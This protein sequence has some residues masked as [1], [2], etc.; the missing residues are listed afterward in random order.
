MNKATVFSIAACAGIACTLACDN[1]DGHYSTRS[2]A[3]ES[4]PDAG[5][6]GAANDDGG[7]AALAPSAA[8]A[9]DAAVDPSSP[10]AAVKSNAPCTISADCQSGQHCDLGECYQECNVSSPCDGGK[11]C[12][13]RGRCLAKGQPDTDPPPLVTKLGTVRAE[14]SVVQLTDRDDELRVHLITDSKNEVR[15]RVEISAPYLTISDLRGA[16]H[17]DLTLNLAVHPSEAGGKQVSGSVRVITNL[18]SV[19]ISTPMRGS[20]TGVYQGTMTYGG[21]MGGPQIGSTHV[22][23][24]LSETQGDILARFAPE[25]S[26]LFP[27]F[28]GQSAATGSGSFTYSD[29]VDIVMRQRIPK[30]FAGDDDPYQR[31]I[32]REVRFHLS[33]GDRGSLDGTFQESIY[34][35]FASPLSLSGRAHFERSPCDASGC[36]PDVETGGTSPAMPAGDGE[37]EPDF[38]S[39]FSGWA[40]TGCTLKMDAPDPA[41]MIQGSA[42]VDVAYHGPFLQLLSGNW[43]L[44]TD[45]PLGDIADTCEADLKKTALDA[46]PKCAQIAPVA[47]RLSMISASNLGTSAYDAFGTL[48]A[49]TV[50]VPLFIA[51][52]D[53]VRAVKDS[54]VQGYRAEIDR[55]KHARDLLRAPT[56]WVLHP[57]LL[58]YLRRADPGAQQR[59]DEAPTS[60]AARTLSRLLFVRST[61]DAEEARIAASSIIGT[62][63]SRRSAA[64]KDGLLAL[65]DAATLY[66]IASSWT[67]VPPELGAAFVDVLTPMDAGFTAF[68]EKAHVLGVADDA[69]PNVYD[70]SRPGTN[71]EQLLDMANSRIGSA[72]RDET[73]FTT[74]GR[75]F[76]DDED[77]LAQELGQLVNGYEAQIR[78]DCGDGFDLV[79]ADWSTCGGDDKGIVGTK[80]IAIDEALARMQSAEARVE[81]KMKAIDIEQDRISQVTGV[82]RGTIAFTDSTGQ[83]LDAIDRATAV[84]NGM[85]KALEIASHA[86]CWNGGAPLAEA[87][88]AFAIE[89]ARGE[90]DVQRQD[91]Q[92]Y[93]DMRVQEDNLK[94]EQIQSA[95]TV[96]G[97]LVDMAQARIETQEDAIGV[98]AA[99]VDAENAL[100][101]AK[102]EF[103]LRARDLARI[104][105]SSLR[106]PTARVLQSRAALNAL[107]SRADAQRSLLQAGRGLEYH[108]N[109][110]LGDVLDDAV[111]NAYDATEQ[112]RLGDCLKNVFDQS[113][114]AFSKTE[115]YTTEL[116]V[117]KLLGID[118][119]RKDDVTGETLSEG[120]QLRRVLLRNENLDGEGGVAIFVSTTL[121]P[122]NE[123]WSSNVC[124]DRIVQ[125]EAEL[126]GDFLGD[127]EAEVHVDLQGGGVL[128]KC[129]ADGLMSWSTSGHA[130]VQAGVNTFGSAPPNDSLHGLAVASSKW[131]IAIPAPSAAPSNADLDLE[132]LEDIVLRVHHEARPIPTN[133]APLAFDCLGAIGG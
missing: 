62:D 91:A 103:D 112:R 133:P 44:T 122:G 16:F 81:D 93:Q 8:V 65:L 117:R 34:A 77:H 21:V 99:R 59:A 131:Q 129:D 24:D 72:E 66:G 40:D 56:T 95:A 47:C 2:E 55:L 69:I 97:L 60:L 98:L 26:L 39:V 116:S 57:R 115:T 107:R 14:Q 30:G 4:P 105:Q 80:L 120:D 70:P 110:P 118:G 50:D 104:G 32:G 49:H 92:T 27:V 124:D 7:A 109:H 20:V 37:A 29:G 106:D 67:A 113:Q 1:T 23:L 126:V 13:P 53:L 101:D 25:R 102:R 121:D 35:L 9:S 51:Q 82:R 128:R 46:S 125:I 64:Q 41:Q 31:D 127:N 15:Y 94:V 36:S 84:V 45:D 96:K 28:E 61:I 132:K 73:T 52:N 54:F 114:I 74:A 63:D 58:E 3:H 79:K 75:Q 11:T 12:S 19:L 86:D 76:E 90:L 88:G 17:D 87:F 6:K 85:E 18:G 42:W 22:G 38:A 10:P 5:V 119:P 108:L 78:A 100:A 123:L 83:K 89:Q 68:V 111:L 71:F 130:V 43:P 33:P 48:Y